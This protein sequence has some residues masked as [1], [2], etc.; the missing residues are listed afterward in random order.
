ML[1]LSS[2]GAEMQILMVHSQLDEVTGALGVVWPEW[3]TEQ[4]K[5]SQKLDF[6]T[7]ILGNWKIIWQCWS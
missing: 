5:P 7:G 3:A 6:R 2:Y 4:L 1:I